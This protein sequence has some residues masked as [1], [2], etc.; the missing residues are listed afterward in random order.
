MSHGVSTAH[1]EHGGEHAHPGESTYVKV[2][3]VLAII[4]IVEVAIYYFGLPHGLLV[5]LLLALSAVKFYTVVS[6][7]MHLK[8]DDRRLA[9]IFAGG[10]AIAGAVFIALDVMQHHH[11]IDYALREFVGQQAAAAE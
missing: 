6:F 7:F 1:A 8:F 4:T 10:L 11:T 3:I 9:F 2:A 5:T